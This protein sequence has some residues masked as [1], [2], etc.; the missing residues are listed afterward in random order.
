MWIVDQGQAKP[1]VAMLAHRERG[2]APES[3]DEAMALRVAAGAVDLTGNVP[4]PYFRYALRAVP[5]HISARARH[6][7]HL[8]SVHRA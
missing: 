2:F 7:I 6:E 4:C 8:E 5:R 3:I 1:S